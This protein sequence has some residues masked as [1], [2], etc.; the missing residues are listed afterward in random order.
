M[1]RYGP[2]PLYIIPSVVIGAVVLFLTIAFF[3]KGRY[4][5]IGFG[6]FFFIPL[7]LIL[8]FVN[9]RFILI[10]QEKLCIKGIFGKRCF[11]WEDIEDVETKRLGIRNTLWIRTKE[12]TAIVPMIFSDLKGLREELEARLGE[13]FKADKWHR[14]PADLLLL[15]LTALFLL[16]ITLTKLF[17][18]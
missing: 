17:L 16:T 6:I 1:K 5:G 2:S 3:F 18:R 15:Y 11:K 9:Y 10:D 8:L 12:H 4:W 7:I 13:R 14:S